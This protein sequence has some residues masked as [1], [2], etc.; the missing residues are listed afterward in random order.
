MA[1]VASGCVVD[2]LMLMLLLTGRAKANAASQWHL[3]AKL[4]R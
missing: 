2:V 1:Q 4:R 3:N